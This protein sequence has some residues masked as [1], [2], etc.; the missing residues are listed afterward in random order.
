MKI[1]EKLS[2]KIADKIESAECYAKCA[3]EYKESHPALAETFYRI[4]NEEMGHMGLLHS[5]VVSI[6]EEY[7]K[8]KGEPPKEMQILYDILHRKH[9]EHAAAVKGMIALYKENIK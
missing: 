9:I 4:A 6:I 1:I 7:R 2:D 3:L 5:Q 8:T